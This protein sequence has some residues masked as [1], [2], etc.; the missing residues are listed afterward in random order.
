MKWLFLVMTFFKVLFRLVSSEGAPSNILAIS[1][2]LLMRLFPLAGGWET[3]KVRVAGDPIYLKCDTM[4]EPRQPV[5]WWYRNKP[6]HPLDHKYIFTEDHGMVI[7]NAT[8]SDEGSYMCVSDGKYWLAAYD[9]RIP[10]RYCSKVYS[11]GFPVPY[12][13]AL[14]S[15]TSLMGIEPV[16]FGVLNVIP[17]V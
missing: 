10:G 6:I 7:L 11:K 9:V 13:L 8:K 5:Q 2:E 3:L 16:Y 17:W 14:P 4:C 12:R 15:N 1:N